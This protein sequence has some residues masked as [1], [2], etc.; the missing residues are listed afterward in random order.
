MA[1]DTRSTDFERAELEWRLPVTGSLLG[2]LVYQWQT[3][4]EFRLLAYLRDLLDI[5]VLDPADGLVTR[6]WMEQVVAIKTERMQAAGFSDAEIQKLTA[7]GASY[8]QEYAESIQRM[9][10]RR[11]GT[12]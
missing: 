12:R 1:G 7:R 9:R 3:D 5:G 10:E 4:P 11:H 8:S 2:S 6:A